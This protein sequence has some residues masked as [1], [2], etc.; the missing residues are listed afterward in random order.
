MQLSMIN[1][2][3]LLQVDATVIIGGL[4]FLTLRTRN[5]SMSRTAQDLAEYFTLGST[6]FTIFLLGISVY[7]LLFGSTRLFDVSKWLT[8]AAIFILLLHVI[9][10]SRTIMEALT[11]HIPRRKDEYGN[12]RK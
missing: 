1:D 7:N 8:V 4:I 11:T 9:G 10:T 3:V 12:D 5:I 2:A 6:Y